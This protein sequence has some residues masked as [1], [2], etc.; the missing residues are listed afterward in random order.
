MEPSEALG[1]LQAHGRHAGAGFPHVGTSHSGETL[2]KP[3]TDRYNQE[4][5]EIP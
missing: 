1:S 2:A 4:F 3:V 5:K